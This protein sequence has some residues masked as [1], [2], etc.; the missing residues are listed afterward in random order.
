MR[1]TITY[2]AFGSETSV[3]FDWEYAVNDFFMLDA[4]YTATNLQ[5]EVSD[6]N[7]PTGY[8]KLWNTIAPALP[9][10][11]THTSLSIGDEVSITDE[12]GTRHF[13]CSKYGWESLNPTPTLNK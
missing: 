6:F 8:L 13:T 5:D 7:F 12:D 10:E 3:S 9:A 1:I 2:K 4:I 11:R